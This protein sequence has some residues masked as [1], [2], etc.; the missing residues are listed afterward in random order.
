MAVAELDQNQRI[1]SDKAKYAN[2]NS[3]QAAVRNNALRDI[4]LDP[5]KLHDR[6]ASLAA[7]Y[8]RWKNVAIDAQANYTPAQQKMIAS[9]YYKSE[10]KPFYDELGV[11][12]PSE[13]QWQK[14]AYDKNG[15]LRVD[16]EDFFHSRM[17]SDLIRGLR[18][19]SQ[20]LMEVGA[21][22][23]NMLGMVTE[24]AKSGKWHDTLFNSNPSDK[25]NFFERAQDITQ[26]KDRPK[27]YYAQT[28]RQK[29]KD[30]P[31]TISETLA[32]DSKIFN[33]FS[34]QD[35]FHQLVNPAEH[36]TDRVAAGAV[37]LVATLPLFTAMRSGN[38]ALGGA[39]DKIAGGNLSRLLS[40]TPKGKLVLKA[41]TDGA[42]GLAYG[43]LSR[44]NADKGQA[45]WDALTW[46]AMG[47][48]FEVGKQKWDLRRALKESGNLDALKEHD[49]TVENLKMSAEEGKHVATPDEKRS[50]IVEAHARHMQVAGVQGVT[51]IYSK[52]L[53]RIAE[54][55]KS[56]ISEEDLIGMRERELDEDPASAVPFHM[57]QNF[58]HDAL[59]GKK[60]SELNPQEQ[61]DLKY[62]I[63]QL[64]NESEDKLNAADGPIKEANI[65]QGM[66]DKKN[67]STEITL[68]FIK[69]KIIKEA[70]EAGLGNT[71][72]PEQIEKIADK[73][74]AE[75]QAKAAAVAEE[76]RNANP[77]G[78]AKDI[79]AV[80]EEVEESGR[81]AGR[82]SGQLLKTPSKAVTTSPYKRIPAD[83]QASHNLRYM[84]YVE[85]AAK[86]KGQ[87][88]TDFYNGMEPED[89]EKDLEEYFYPKDLKDAGIY[90][91]KEHTR[92]G[93]Q[94]PNFLAFMYNY[95]DQMPKEMAAKLRYELE[96][97]LKF[98][99]NFKGYRI[100]DDQLWHYALQMYNHVDTFLGSTSFIKK[101]ERN[102]FRSTQSDLLNPTVYQEQLL[103][104]MHS[105]NL[106]LLSEMFQRPKEKTAARTAYKILAGTLNDSFAKKPSLLSAQ[107]Y[108]TQAEKISTFLQE[109]GQKPSAKYEAVPW[110]F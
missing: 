84:N 77:I 3:A 71:L 78:R 70:T 79:A 89:F 61:I 15:V 33:H 23:A 29:L 97:S 67:P 81:E 64:I 11:Q 49:S 56:G 98:E 19:A 76:H 50:A 28:L 99:K 7:T 96:D 87:N 53:Q 107:A 31:S 36:F 85:A 45:K 73:Q 80:R 62:Q 18:G 54:N 2:A 102:I 104:E 32:R 52:A 66:P 26:S 106:K 92:E 35:E 6:H 101:G 17:T 21:T 105:Q 108:R 25:R 42:D 60:L 22:G 39:I 95:K 109:Q 5:H 88:L 68:G 10:V 57:A 59:N 110:N 83:R 1:I 74:Y 14:Y 38:A 37:E 75:A 40:A 72:K 41:L 51:H 69:A 93:K 34:D 58:I 16:V 44:P 43:T 48:V 103:G 8:H 100:T 90:F 4:T 13:E 30:R 86:N 94:N 46:A 63:G 27:A 12:G 20:Q 24:A 55:E 9:N 65:V 91:E 47:T 82:K